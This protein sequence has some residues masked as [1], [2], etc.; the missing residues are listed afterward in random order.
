MKTKILIVIIA[1]LVTA[2]IF[3]VWNSNR[4]AIVNGPENAVYILDARTGGLW[5]KRY[6]QSLYLG[7]PSEDTKHI[8]LQKGDWWENDQSV[9]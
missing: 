4:Y 1:V 7:S 2:A 5:I 6:D 3:S 9:D 8:V